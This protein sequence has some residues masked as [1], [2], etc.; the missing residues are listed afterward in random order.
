MKY[1]NKYFTTD[2]CLAYEHLRIY[3]KGQFSK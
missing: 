2:I 1:L 3:F